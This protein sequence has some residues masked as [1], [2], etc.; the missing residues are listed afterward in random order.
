[1]LRY[2]LNIC[3]GAIIPKKMVMKIELSE[4]LKMQLYG[5]RNLTDNNVYSDCDNK[6]FLTDSLLFIEV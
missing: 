4:M 2:E 6:A 3:I 1:M 5:Y